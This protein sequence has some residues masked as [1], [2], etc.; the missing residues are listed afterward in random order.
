MSTAA[1]VVRDA[2]FFAKVK[3][4]RVETRT[5]S[6]IEIDRAGKR[7]LARRLSEGTETWL[8]YDS[9]AVL[10]TGACPWCRPFPAPTGQAS[11]LC[12]PSRMPNRV[13]AAVD[14]GG[15]VEAVVVGGG[16]IGVEMAEALAERGCRVTVVEMQPQILT[17]LDWEMAKALESHMATCGVKVLTNTAAREI[18]GED[19]VTGVVTSAGRLSADLV[20]LAVGV[21]PNIAL[22]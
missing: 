16:L 3:N 9:L 22:G 17:L 19:H 1:G 2:G 14:A 6:A 13:R 11:S 21:L 8:A 20:I 7:V 18:E 10:A 4:V 15:V 12:I 5:G